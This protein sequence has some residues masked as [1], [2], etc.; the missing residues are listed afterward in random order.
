M[1]LKLE[2][3]NMKIDDK[4]LLND[5]SLLLKGGEV[6]CLIGMNGAGKTTLANV[7]MGIRRADSGKILFNNKDITKLNITKRAELGITLGWQKPANIEGLSVKDYVRLGNKD[8]NEP[9]VKNVLEAVGLDYN[10]YASR[11][12]DDKLS[13]GERKR[14][15]LAAVINMDAKFVVL[16]EPDSGID[17]VSM[18][19]IKNIIKKLKESGKSVLLIT[20]KEDMILLGDK[21]G[22]MCAGKVIHEGNP[23][24]IN[25]HFKKGCRI[26][27]SMFYERTE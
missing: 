4:Q 25:E 6:Y 13:G 11:M 1:I 17:L 21:A 16:D 19:F 14:V 8:S 22:I 15:E 9:D 23:A 2:K 27:R 3:I 26:C 12:L 24:D 20:H 5:F 7:I 10:E 18:Q